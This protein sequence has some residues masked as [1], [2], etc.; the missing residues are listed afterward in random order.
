[1]LTVLAF[2]GTYGATLLLLVTSLVS[3]RRPVLIDV[4]SAGAVALLVTGLLRVVLGVTAGVQFSSSYAT[5]DVGIPV[6]SLAVA[7]AMALSAR[8]YLA[9][10][11]QRLCY[12]AF[13]LGAVCLVVD[14]KG[15]LLSVLASVLIGWGTAAGVRLVT[16]TPS[17]LPGADM[18]GAMLGELGIDVRSVSPTVAQT[19]GAA[20]FDAVRA[21]GASL[22]VSVYGRDARD[23]ELA[24][25]LGRTIAYRDEGTSLFVTR[26]QQAEHEAY[27]TLRAAAALHGARDRGA[28]SGSCRAVTRR[29]RR[30]PAT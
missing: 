3:R 5:I 13:T 14:G 25:T 1:M 26:L 11:F 29:R 23:A 6:P 22:R 24:S 17:G 2:T 16:G 12:L 19:W 4:L 21:D 10:S 18:V 30:H 28:R 7:V 15:L 8:P 20:R 9:R 27:V